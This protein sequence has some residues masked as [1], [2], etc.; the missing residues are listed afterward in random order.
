MKVED[1]HNNG[2]DLRLGKP[3]FFWEETVHTCGPQV[4][5]S[6]CTPLLVVTIG[7]G[8][9]RSPEIDGTR[10]FSLDPGGTSRSQPRTQTESRILGAQ[11]FPLRGQVHG[12]RS[13][14]DDMPGVTGNV[15][16]G[17]PVIPGLGCSCYT[18]DTRSHCWLLILPTRLLLREPSILV[19][20]WLQ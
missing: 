10:F 5:M 8:A 17:K 9:H 15:T 1:S 6:E 4:P 18:T 16:E 7:T 19:Q 12:G 3:K 14:S 2:T 13:A 11:P 20:G